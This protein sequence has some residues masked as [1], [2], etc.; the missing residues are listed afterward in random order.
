MTDNWDDYADEWDANTDAISY[1]EN[2]YKSLLKVVDIE[3]QNILDFGCGTGLLTER[4]ASSANNIVAIDSSIKMIAVLKSKKLSNVISISE[5]LTSKVIKRN[6]AFVKKF[7]VI[8]ASSVFSFLPDYEA[9]QI[10]LKSLL[11]CGGVLIQWDWLSVE[12]NSG[13]GIPEFGFSETRIDKALKDA[14]FEQVSITKPFFQIG[15]TQIGSK[16]KMPVVMGIAK[17]L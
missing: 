9:T 14:G 2:A 1:S 6:L 15:S 12:N 13:V 3:D 11:A 5:P 17:N 7:N 8:V 10:R 4:M 16:G